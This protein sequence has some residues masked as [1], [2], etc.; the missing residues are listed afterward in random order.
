MVWQQDRLGR[1]LTHLVNTK[2]DLSNR[3]IGLLVLTGQGAEIDTI[4]S[5][6]RM[7][8]GIFA[9]LAKFQRERWFG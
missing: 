5:A 9:I 8:F 7:I 2:R 6:G 1:A 4:T 3:G